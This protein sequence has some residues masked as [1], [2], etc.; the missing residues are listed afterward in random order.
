LAT[1]AA[2]SKENVREDNYLDKNSNLDG[3]SFTVFW[4][5]IVRNFI[6]SYFLSECKKKHVKAPWA[7]Q[8]PY[9]LPSRLQ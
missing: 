4:G 9:L 8:N 7:F 1:S 5:F 3:I 2:A 6:I